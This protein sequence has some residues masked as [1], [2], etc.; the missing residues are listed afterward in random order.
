MNIFYSSDFMNISIQ[1]KKKVHVSGIDVSIHLQQ[2]KRTSFAFIVSS[3]LQD[4][5]CKYSE[6]FESNYFN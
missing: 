3:C 5:V 4:K 1:I 6:L 2:E